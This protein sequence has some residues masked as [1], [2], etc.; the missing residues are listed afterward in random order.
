[1]HPKAQYT[2]ITRTNVE[3]A[4]SLEQTTGVPFGIVLNWLVDYK[5]HDGTVLMI[6]LLNTKPGVSVEQL[7]QAARET[8]RKTRALEAGLPGPSVAERGGE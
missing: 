8:A 3:K 2:T 7:E 6:A 4:R 5:L 1:M